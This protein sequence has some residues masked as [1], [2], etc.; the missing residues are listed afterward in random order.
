MK[1]RN[2]RHRL[3]KT[4]K[5]L[6]IVQKHL[7][8]VACQFADDKGENGHLMIRLPLGGDPTKLG[9]DFEGRGFVFTR[10]RSPWLGADIFRGTKPDQ[11]RV[12]IE[13]EIPANRLSRVPDH[14]QEFSFKAKK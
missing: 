8:D 6:V 14:E 2:L 13:V 4:A 12:I 10:T 5:L 3:E 9:S 11:P 1:P 7:P